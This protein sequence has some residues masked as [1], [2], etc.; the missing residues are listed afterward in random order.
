MKFL[1]KKEIATNKV[2]FFTFDL[3]PQWLTS[4]FLGAF[5][6]WVDIQCEQNVF[7]AQNWLFVLCLSSFNIHF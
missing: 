3:F 7:S 1:P 6:K 2:L 5:P 4:L